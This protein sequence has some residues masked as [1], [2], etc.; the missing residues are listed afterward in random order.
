MQAALTAFPQ[1]PGIAGGSGARFVREVQALEFGQDVLG[2]ERVAL[3]AGMQAVPGQQLA[4]QLTVSRELP[5]IYF[6]LPLLSL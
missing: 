5:S 1:T 4:P 6:Y 2:E 3:G